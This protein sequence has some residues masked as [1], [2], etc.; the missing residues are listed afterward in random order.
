MY[1]FSIS[2]VS[3]GGGGE[4]DQ[5]GDC[6][7]PDAKKPHV[8]PPE[9]SVSFQHPISELVS[10]HQGAIFNFTCKQTFFKK[11]KM[12]QNRLVTSF[13]VLQRFSLGEQI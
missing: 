12:C 8:A 11:S 6:G 9:P 5:G 2:I 1:S 3:T 7:P 13:M 10:K 4:V